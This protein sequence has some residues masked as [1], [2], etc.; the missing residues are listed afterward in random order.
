MMS[1]VRLLAAFAVLLCFEFVAAGSA[2]AQQ[3]PSKPA[4]PPSA[5]GPLNDPVLQ[6]KV[7]LNLKDATINQVAEALSKVAN[8]SLIVE[9]PASM[10]LRPMTV[11]INGSR[12][13]DVM[14]I[15]GQMY[16][17]RWRRKNDV[18]LLTLITGQQDIEQFAQSAMETIYN[19]VLTPEQRT[20]VDAEGS[21]SGKDLTP[22][23]QNTLRGYLQD[24][25]SMLF[26]SN[27]GETRVDKVVLDR[28]GN[29]FSINLG[30]NSEGS[31]P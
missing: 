12:L 18:F 15:L 21:I 14:D 3:K 2:F 11:A 28:A 26:S 31:N 23:Q 30:G 13:R 19:D 7:T 6:Q 27:M 29:K 5:P 24:M 25:M 16:G 17:Y 1:P 22:T 4:A 10:A 20:K 8:I 9:R